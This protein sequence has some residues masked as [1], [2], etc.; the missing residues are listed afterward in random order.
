MQKT[1]FLNNPTAKYCELKGIKEDNRFTVSQRKAIHDTVAIKQISNKMSLGYFQ[2]LTVVI[3]L[4]GMASVQSIPVQRMTRASSATAETT[5]IISE[6]IRRSLIRRTSDS[7]GL[8]PVWLNAIRL[9]EDNILKAQVSWLIMYAHAY[10]LTLTNIAVS[11]LG[12]Q[13][14]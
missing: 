14:V 10:T 5:V 8:F 3:I 13:S 6:K 11:T 2:H 7:R 12:T 4:L 9:A 1:T